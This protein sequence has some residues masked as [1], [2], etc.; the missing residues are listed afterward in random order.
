MTRPTTNVQTGDQYILAARRQAAANLAAHPDR[1]DA[2][3]PHTGLLC[4]PEGTGS[5]LC[6]YPIGDGHPTHVPYV[7]GEYLR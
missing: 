7:E 6:R 5:W 3:P 1:R 4:L 2:G